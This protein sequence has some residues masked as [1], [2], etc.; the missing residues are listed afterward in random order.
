M[1]R[2]T[3]AAF[4]RQLVLAALPAAA[5][6]CC[7]D[8]RGTV[9]T[10]VDAFTVADGAVGDGGELPA[11]VCTQHCQ[12]TRRSTL[13]AVYGCRIGETTDGGIVALEC[14]EGYTQCA[15]FVAGGRP[16]AG[17]RRRDDVVA[18][19]VVGAYFSAMA[20]VEGAAVAGFVELADE[21]A[22]WGAPAQLV[23]EA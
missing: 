22:R 16:P 12:A 9:R 4:L 5:A 18:A 19:D 11:D 14:D 20:H 13:K 21:L 8:H 6:G 10:E 3:L 2:N 1:N 7:S 15:S 23:A 17:L